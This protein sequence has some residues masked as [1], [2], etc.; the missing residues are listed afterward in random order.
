MAIIYF[1]FNKM[2]YSHANNTI[3]RFMF[4]VTRSHRNL[5]DFFDPCLTIIV[6]DF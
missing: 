4:D 5:H 2:E 3:I 1:G 6:N